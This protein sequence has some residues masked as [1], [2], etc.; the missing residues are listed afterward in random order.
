M[1]PCYLFLLGLPLVASSS[2]TWGSC[3]TPDVQ[4]NF[5][6]DQFLGKWYEIQR[7]APMS[8]VECGEC[9]LQRLDRSVALTCSERVSQWWVLAT[10]YSSVSVIYSC[11]NFMG[12]F[13]LENACIMSRN[14]VLP[15]EVL[16]EARMVLK[17]GGINIRHLTTGSVPDA[18]DCLAELGPAL[19]D[20]DSQA[21]Q[22]VAPALRQLRVQLKLLRQLF[23][24][25]A[26]NQSVPNHFAMQ[27]PIAAV[28]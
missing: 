22:W 5:S 12:M 26:Y 2:F 21:D 27:L 20:L 1:F 4:A 17:N 7:I 10:D 11:K 8:L 13:S 6:M 16:N 19:L 23:I 9:T 24:A 14:P 15:S 18:Q 3:L 28:L 25:Q